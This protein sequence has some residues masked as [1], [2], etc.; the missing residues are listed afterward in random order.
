MSERGSDFCLIALLTIP[1]QAQCQSLKINNCPHLVAEF[2]EESVRRDNICKTQC[3]FVLDV[4]PGA[5]PNFF[6][7]ADTLQAPGGFNDL[8][9]GVSYSKYHIIWY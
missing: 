1:L 3:S 5:D 4:P 7:E 6:L 2:G 9:A 8:S